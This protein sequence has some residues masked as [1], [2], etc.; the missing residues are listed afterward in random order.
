MHRR[1]EHQVARAPGVE[2]AVG[3]DA[4][5]PE[6]GHLGDVHPAE[7]LPLVG[8]Q[9]VDP[10]VVGAVA[11]GVVI[12]ER[13]RL[14]EV[15]QHLGVP[16]E[17]GVEHLPGEGEGQPHGVAVVVV[18]H[19]V[20]PVD[21][22]GRHGLGM[23]EVPAIDVHHAVA[24]V[25]LDDRG[26]QGDHVVADRADVRALV[27]RQPVGELHEGGGRAG[28]GG[29]DGP[30]DVV[31]GHAR[32][33]QRVG[34]LVVELEEPGV[35]ELGEPGV[36]R[37]LLLEVLLRADRH[38]DPLATLL[39]LADRDHPHPG[40]GRREHPEVAVHVRRI[41]E[42]PRRSGDVSQDRA[43][44][45]HGLRRRQVV[46]ERRVELRRRGVFADPRRGVGVDGLLEV[47]R[48]LGGDARL[49]DHGGQTG[50]GQQDGK[51]EST[52]S[53]S[54]GRRRNLPAH[55]IAIPGRI[56][57]LYRRRMLRR[58]NTWAEEPSE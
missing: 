13:H 33:D 11:H 34:A 25:D 58:A 5:H 29:V 18:R 20:P 9:G 50:R 47:G 27:D 15:V 55:P 40:G 17:I 22:A 4:R 6:L 44:G 21:Q 3:E 26:D 16:A 57:A 12:E 28:L 42:D 38:R 10:G 51:G 53:E 32:G 8:E 1:H 41:G 19:V 35:R 14:V 2:V 37:L 56:E 54:S 7:E 36:V 30:R 49:G 46:R 39:A 23:G 24:A 45:G 31:D 48:E 52:H 43:G